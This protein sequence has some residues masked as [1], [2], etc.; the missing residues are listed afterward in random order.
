VRAED[1]RIFLLAPALFLAGIGLVVLS[2]VLYCSWAKRNDAMDADQASAFA[3]VRVS[4]V[5]RLWALLVEV[6]YQAIS[7]VLRTLHAWRLLPA[8]SGAPGHTPVLLV[9]GYTE[10]AGTMLPLALR[11]A[12]A[13]FNPI[14]IDFP[15]TLHRIESN[16]DFLARRVAEVRSVTAP[17]APVAVVAHSMGGLITR[18]LLHSRDDHGVIAFA[19]IGT[20]FRGTHMARL[21]AALRLGHCLTQMCPGSEFMQRFPP[22]LPP[23]VPTLSLIACQ[24]NIISPEWSAVIAGAETRVLSEPWGHQAPLFMNEVYRHVERF[25]LAHGV[26][27]R[28]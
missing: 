16:A 23:R 4:F 9:P 10:N 13:G 19:A 14:L 18:T 6:V 7:L 28:T 27:R 3:G 17:G 24:E 12:R 25:L 15:S 20:P 26:T 8:P 11:L 1:L 2:G 5:H 22:S 21:G